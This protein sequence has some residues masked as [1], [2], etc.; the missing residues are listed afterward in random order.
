M[1]VLLYNNDCV[2][3]YIL[4]GCGIKSFLQSFDVIYIGGGGFTE[5]IS[6]SAV[7]SVI[8]CIFTERLDRC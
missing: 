8:I 5:G 7:K 3:K 6:D 1:K 4:R 2:S